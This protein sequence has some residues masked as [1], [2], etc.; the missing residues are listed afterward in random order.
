[1]YAMTV[2]VAFRLALGDLNNLK[3]FRLHMFVSLRRF[4]LHNVWL[5]G[6]AANKYIHMVTALS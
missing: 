5:I 2:L 3:I 6:E 4:S 1:M